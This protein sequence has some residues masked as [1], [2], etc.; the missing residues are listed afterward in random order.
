MPTQEEWISPSIIQVTWRAPLDTDDLETCFNTLAQLIGKSN[1]LADIIF[2]LRQAGAIPVMAP[3]YAIQSRFLTHPNRRHVVVVHADGMAMSMA[4]F[5]GKTTG[6]PMKF[7]Y[8]LNEAY[9]FL[10]HIPTLSD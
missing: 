6:T 10:R 1:A 3:L 5:A 4:K 8:T 2:D 7:V 9:I